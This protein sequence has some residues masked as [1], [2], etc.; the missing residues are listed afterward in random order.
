MDSKVGPVGVG[1]YGQEGAVRGW[2]N[3]GGQKYRGL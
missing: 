2:D 1:A 3:P